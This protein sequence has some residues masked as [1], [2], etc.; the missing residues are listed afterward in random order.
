MIQWTTDLVLRIVATHLVTAVAFLWVG[1]D[2]G[3]RRALQQREQDRETS[4]ASG[5]R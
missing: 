1:W 2:L 5:D 3:R 4:H